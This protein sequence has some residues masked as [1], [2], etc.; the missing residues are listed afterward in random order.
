MLLPACS[1]PAMWRWISRLS[2]RPWPSVLAVT[3]GRRAASGGWSH[4]WVMPTSRPPR[5]RANTISVALGRSEQMRNASVI[6]GQG[7]GR[8]ARGQGARQAFAGALPRFPRRKVGRLGDGYQ[9]SFLALKG[10]PIQDFENVRTI[11]T[12]RL[13]ALVA[14]PSEGLRYVVV[15]VRRWLPVASLNQRAD[16]SEPCALKF[17]PMTPRNRPVGASAAASAGTRHR[18]F[19]RLPLHADGRRYPRD[20]DQQSASR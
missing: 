1:A 17:A 6:A 3:A 8:R 9:A 5:P 7:S 15:G 2:R 4:S 16:N 18:P 14:A 19:T 12:R 11:T 20:Q 13:S 10:N